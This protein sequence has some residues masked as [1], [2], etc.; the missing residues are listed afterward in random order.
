MPRDRT[1]ASELAS[2]VLNAKDAWQDARLNLERTKTEYE[3]AEKRL[4][5]ARRELD[6]EL[7]RVED[8]FGEMTDGFEDPDAV[9]GALHSVEFVGESIGSA[10]R[11][12]LRQLKKVSIARLV[13][14]MRERGFQFQTEVPARELHG[15][16]VK[17]AAWAK[18]DKKTD[19][20][21]Y[22]VEV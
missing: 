11:S 3:Y 12:S 15:A 8:W 2:K 21:E 5:L 10:A 4:I 1:K 6:L 17:Q 14:H 13:A 9:L 18:K 16:L 22:V 7:G 19:T 20:W